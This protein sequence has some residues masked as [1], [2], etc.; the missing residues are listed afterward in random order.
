MASELPA[1][2]VAE[3]RG[4]EEAH[5]LGDARQ[6]GGEDVSLTALFLEF[7]GRVVGR[8]LTEAVADEEG[9]DEK[10][11]E[12]RDG[13]GGSPGD[14]AAEVAEGNVG[15]GEPETDR[16]AE[17]VQVGRHFL[18]GVGGCVVVGSVL[19]ESEEGP[20]AFAFFTFDAAETEEDEDGDEEGDDADDVVAVLDGLA[21]SDTLDLSEPCW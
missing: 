8:A 16:V 13:D 10:G 9:V 4:A 3:K 21:E 12:E 19:L 6:D 20:E 1:G 14:E 18:G 11:H 2:E 7:W 15:V 5:Q 17:E